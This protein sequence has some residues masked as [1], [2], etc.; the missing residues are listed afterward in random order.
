MVSVSSTSKADNRNI[1]NNYM[2]DVFADENIS[3]PLSVDTTE[4]TYLI[5]GS[6]ELINKAKNN[7]KSIGLRNTRPVELLKQKLEHLLLELT[8]SKTKIT[9]FGNAMEMATDKHLEHPNVK[10]ANRRSYYLYTE[11]KHLSN[12]HKNIRGLYMR[13]KEDMIAVDHNF[14][15]KPMYVY[16]GFK[17]NGKTIVNVMLNKKKLLIYLK[18]DKLDDP[19]NLTEKVI[20]TQKSMG[21]YR[22]NVSTEDELAYTISLVEQIILSKPSLEKENSE[23]VGD[24]IYLHK[25]E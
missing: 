3:A 21:K 12:V 24:N 14:I 25:T 22:I 16:L 5:M 8:I 15:I 6:N 11:N 20:T 19:R 4:L 17:I 9:S 2:F 7:K 13:F 23:D 10:K 1:N 18:T